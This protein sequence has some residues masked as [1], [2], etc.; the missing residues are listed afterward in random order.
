MLSTETL[1]Q[2]N[3]LLYEV[4][5]H[6]DLPLIEWKALRQVRQFLT[7]EVDRRRKDEAAKGITSQA[8]QKQE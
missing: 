3:V 1:Q 5:E 7:L 6:M 2:A 4:Q 8:A